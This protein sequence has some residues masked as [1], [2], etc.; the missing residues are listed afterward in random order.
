MPKVLD[1]LVPD[2][3]R[4]KRKASAQVRRR[5]PSGGKGATRKRPARAVQASKAPS[6]WLNRAL[7]LGAVLV[8][9]VAGAR[10]YLHLQSLP[11][12]QITV[13]GKLEH[14]QATAVQE[15]VQAT[16]SGGFLSA[17]LEQMRAQLEGLPWI[18]SATVRRRWPQ[19]LEI[20]VLE[21]LPIA[22]WGE[23]GFLNHE[24]GVFRS[25][26]SGDWDA[27]PLLQGPEGSAP[28]LMSRYQRLLEMLAPLGLQLEQLTM[29]ERGQV[30]V[31]LAGGVRLILGG[32]N[33]RERMQRFTTVYRRE[34]APRAAEIERIDLRYATGLAVAYRQTEP[35]AVAGL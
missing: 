34:L 3:P 20:H 14:T 30:E 17:D 32:E 13:T 26:K 15:M 24:G 27:L 18:Y 29:D 9:A 33:L 11:V 8:V 21:Q 6:L 16:L 5:K 25:D 23:G 31:A 35:S 28:G 19:T 22:R 7:I 2:A 4:G 1:K 10:G 12:Q